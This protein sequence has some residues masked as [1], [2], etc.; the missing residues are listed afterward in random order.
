MTDIEFQILDEVYFLQPYS[1]L[2][3][4]LV[5][6]DSELSAGL[7]SLLEKGWVR[8]YISPNEEVDYRHC[9]YKDNYWSL[10]FLASKK[11]LVAHNSNS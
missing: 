5:L 10:Y 1:Y 3:K 11:G 2:A 9:D 4:T 6:T 7:L 8:C